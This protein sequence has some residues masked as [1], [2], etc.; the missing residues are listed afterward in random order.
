MLKETFFL[1]AVILALFVLLITETS[2]SG[3]TNSQLTLN[4]IGGQK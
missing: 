1:A 2:H 4:V 3:L